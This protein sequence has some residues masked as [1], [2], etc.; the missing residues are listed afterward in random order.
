MSELSTR[1]YLIRAIHGWCTDSALTPYLA[2][3]VNDK[4]EVPMAFVKVD[5]G[6]ATVAASRTQ[7][8][9]A[10]QGGGEVHLRAV[11]GMVRSR[12]DAGPNATSLSVGDADGGFLVTWVDGSTRG[13]ATLV[14]PVTLVPGVVDQLGSTGTAAMRAVSRPTERRSDGDRI[15]M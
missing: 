2:V 11:P 5:P 12:F 7:A 9:V 6:T 4:T 15:W 3:R 14:D 1:P 10:W 8:L 13:L